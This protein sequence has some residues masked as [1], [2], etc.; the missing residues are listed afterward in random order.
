MRARSEP[1]ATLG[2]MVL[3]SGCQREQHASWDGEVEDLRLLLLTRVLEADE[4]GDA[5]PRGTTGDVILELLKE[6][7]LVLPAVS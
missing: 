7:G 6:L 5:L 2:R 4:V 3:D 1:P